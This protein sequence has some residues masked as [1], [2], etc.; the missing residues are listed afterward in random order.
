[1]IKEIVF[2]LG[3]VYFEAGTG[4]VKD[5]LLSMVPVSREIADEIFEGYPHK[6]GFLYRNG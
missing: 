3:G 6:E 5:K 4:A 1:M 2:D